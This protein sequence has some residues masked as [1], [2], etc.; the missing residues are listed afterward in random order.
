MAFVSKIRFIEH[1]CLFWCQPFVHFIWLL[2]LPYSTLPL[3]ILVC[4]YLSSQLKKIRH[5]QLVDIPCLTVWPDYAHRLVQI[6]A[7]WLL[8]GKRLL[9][10]RVT[11]THIG[12]K[13]KPLVFKTSSVALQRNLILYCQESIDL[14]FPL[15]RLHSLTGSTFIIV[16]E[17]VRNNS[18]AG[19]S[20]QGLSMSSLLCLQNKSNTW[21]QTWNLAVSQL[22][23]WR[24][25]AEVDYPPKHSGA[26]GN[27]IFVQIRSLNTCVRE[28]MNL[29]PM[30][31]MSRAVP[32]LEGLNKL[33]W[34]SYLR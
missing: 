18:I 15:D 13:F 17:G 3:Q 12:V 22:S 31:C 1:F 19:T 10:I 26:C 4:L 33:S 7:S 11:Q 29:R 6:A 16:T 5:L 14:F 28:W 20:C 25:C 2:L 21:I 9:M 24:L 30:L 32:V 34:Q 27:P 8:M 23:H